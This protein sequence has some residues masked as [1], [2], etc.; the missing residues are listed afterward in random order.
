M[1][2]TSALRSS[3]HGGRRSAGGRAERAVLTLQGGETDIH[4]AFED[5]RPT[6]LQGLWGEVVKAVRDPL[7]KLAELAQLAAQARLVSR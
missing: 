4:G 5:A 3:A 6:A 1:A 2:E 7:L